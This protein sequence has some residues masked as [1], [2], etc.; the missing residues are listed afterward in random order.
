[1]SDAAAGAGGGVLEVA[2]DDPRLGLAGAAELVRDG[3][4]LVPWRL[5]VVGERWLADPRMALKASTPSG[6]RF[7]FR[8][9]AGALHW[10]VDV[11]HPADTE[12]GPAPFDVLVDGELLARVRAGSEVAPYGGPGEV[13]VELPAGEKLVQVWLPQLGTVRLGRLRLTGA[14]VLEPHAGGPR[15]VLYGS[16]ITHCIGVPG[17]SETWP[18]LAARAHGWDLR[19]L[20]LAG[21]CHLDPAVARYLRDCPADLIAL[22]VGINVYGKSSLSG[23]AFASALAGFVATVRDGHPD[24]PLVLISPISSPDREERPNAVDLTLADVRREVERVHGFLRERGDAALHLVDGPAVLG[25][26]E[27]DLL[28]DGLHPTPEGYRLMATRLGPLLDAR[29]PR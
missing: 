1:V 5:P 13:A 26:G 11:Q 3:G 6:V 27:A 12:R 4:W 10:P 8:T 25:P 15:V 17:P 18:A 28:A 22:C 29:L 7:A 14:T 20:G 2:A 9:D 19:S 21:E 23:R 24:A 16:S